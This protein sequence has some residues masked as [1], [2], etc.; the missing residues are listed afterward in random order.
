ME[1]EWWRVGHILCYEQKS[2]QNFLGVQV[3]N[4]CIRTLL[5]TSIVAPVVAQTIPSLKRTRYTDTSYPR[6][7]DQ[8]NSRPRQEAQPLLILLQWNH[9]RE[10]IL[11]WPQAMNAMR[12]FASIVNTVGCTTVFYSISRAASNPDSL[13]IYFGLLNI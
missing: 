7:F 10:A 1:M 2:S 11:A 6:T 3:I 13:Y 5:P 8:V 4:S 9:M 12:I